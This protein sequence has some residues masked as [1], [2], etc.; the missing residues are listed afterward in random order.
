[1]TRWYDK[2]ATLSEK[3]NAFKEMEQVLKD[4]LIKGM[5]S[6]VTDYDPNLLSYEK[7][8]DFP[9]AVDRQRWY[10]EDPYLWLLF[11]TLQMADGTLLQSITTYL[12]EEM[13][14]T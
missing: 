3:L 4:R 9:L 7:A 10:D 11:N 8:F 1:M 13:P 2:H 5:M 12:D 6:L 14:A